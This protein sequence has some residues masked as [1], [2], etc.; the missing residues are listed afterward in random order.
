M[1][2]EFRRITFSHSE[3]KDALLLCRND[4]ESKIRSSE[5]VSIATLRKNQQ[6][7]LK[8]ELFDFSKEKKSRL[9]IDEDVVRSCLVDYC[10]TQNIPLPRIAEKDLRIIEN[11]ICID[12]NFDTSGT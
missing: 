1:A 10:Q 4:F 12:M 11:K 9:E 2:R 8:L 7:L 6:H 5:V 3:L